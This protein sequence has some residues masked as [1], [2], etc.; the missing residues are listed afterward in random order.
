MQP[1]TLEAERVDMERWDAQQREE[2]RI[3]EEHEK[4]ETGL[5]RWVDHDVMPEDKT[6]GEI[7]LK[8]TLPVAQERP[9][10]LLTLPVPELGDYMKR[11]WGA[12]QLL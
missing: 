3:E 5:E 4:E 11:C 1:P 12:N 6:P 9:K 10:L 8:D 7:F 2:D